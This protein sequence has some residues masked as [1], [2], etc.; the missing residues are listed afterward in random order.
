MVHNKLPAVK[1]KI[2]LSQG[3]P[4]LALLLGIAY[5]LPV[6]LVFVG[7]L[8]FSY[9]Y[10]I[11]VISTIIMIVYS[12]FRGLRLKELGF[13]FDTLKQ[14]LIMNV[15]LVVIDAAIIIALYE[16]KLIRQPTVP[17]W[18]LFY[19]FYV[20]ISSPA[21]EFLYRSVVFAEMKRAHIDGFFAQILISTVTYCF[22]HIIYKDVLTLVVTFT[23]GLIWGIIYR[24]AP[25]FWGVALS[26]AILGALSITV[27]LV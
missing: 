21:Q 19:V 13:R 11:L 20:F 5:Y 10:L 16:A 24:K 9:R 12:F 26:H 15:V 27:G 17:N 8:P 2:A 3:K 22:L 7:I 18:N 1:E 4:Y 25:N 6:A 14:S 23:I